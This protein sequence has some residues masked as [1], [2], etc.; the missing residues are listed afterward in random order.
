M[1]RPGG[2]RAAFDG[3]KNMV[4]ITSDASRVHTSSVR[5]KAFSIITSP[6]FANPQAEEAHPQIFLGIAAG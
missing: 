6:P 3:L 5:P 1:L 2:V 4:Q